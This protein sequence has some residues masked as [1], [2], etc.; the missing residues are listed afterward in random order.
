M[1][2]AKFLLF[3]GM[4]IFVLVVISF[5]LREFCY[6]SFLKPN[7]QLLERQVVQGDY[8]K[9][10]ELVANSQVLQSRYCSL[11][12]FSISIELLQFIL[13]FVLY[14]IYSRSKRQ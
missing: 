10:G 12:N 1:K 2:W 11:Q 6:Y 8:T 7:L 14:K 13:F 3:A 9:I 4:S 5:L